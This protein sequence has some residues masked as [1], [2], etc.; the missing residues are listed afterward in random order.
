MNVLWNHFV[1]LLLGWNLTGYM[2]F[3]MPT[4]IL[5]G[6]IPLSLL[7]MQCM[8]SYFLLVC[9]LCYS[10]CISIKDKCALFTLG[11]RCIFCYFCSLYPTS[12]TALA[13]VKRDL[14][15]SIQ[16]IVTRALFLSASM[17]MIQLFL[18]IV[19][20]HHRLVKSVIFCTEFELVLI[21]VEKCHWSRWWVMS[22]W[23]DQN[24]GL[25]AS[26]IRDDPGKFRS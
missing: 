20:L 17:I 24:T 8:W 10:C 14:Q 21:V 13:P 1:F 4:Q 22:S 23:S 12:P 16:H 7:S 11:K 6:H 19:G 15:V 25:I 26:L 5:N 3:R 18:C 2:I 9:Q